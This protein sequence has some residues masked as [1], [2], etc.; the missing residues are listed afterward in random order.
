MLLHLPSHGISD[1]SG[2]RVLL[3]DLLVEFFCI[4]RRLSDV[5]EQSIIFDCQRTFNLLWLE[6]RCYLRFD[7][8]REPFCFR[9]QNDVVQVLQDHSAS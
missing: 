2:T 9:I 1:G 6:E 7:E 4:Q 3:T 5:G 8:A